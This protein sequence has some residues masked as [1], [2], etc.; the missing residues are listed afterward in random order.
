M[1][2]EAMAFPR[3]GLSSAGV[4]PNPGRGKNAEGVGSCPNFQVGPEVWWWQGTTSSPAPRADPSP[5]CISSQDPTAPLSPS[6]LLPAKEGS[7][8]GS[9]SR[10]GSLIP[11]T[12]KFIQMCTLNK[13]TCQVQSFKS[14]RT[15]G[16]INVCSKA[17]GTGGGFDH[18][19][20]ERDLLCAGI[21]L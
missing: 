20:R 14:L 21:W 2:I 4:Q 16:L 1:L 6:L 3:Q 19:G 9:Q 13:P 5:H 12:T 7:G 17:S 10:Q 18:H 15:K 11:P 8:G